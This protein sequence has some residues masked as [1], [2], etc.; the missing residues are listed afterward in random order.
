MPAIL[1]RKPE[2]RPLLLVDLIEQIDFPG[3]VLARGG[4]VAVVAAV[5]EKKEVDAIGV[6]GR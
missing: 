4:L 3:Q 6:G 5:G 1:F 2:G